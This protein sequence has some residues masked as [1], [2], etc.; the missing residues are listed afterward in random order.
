MGLTDRFCEEQQKG[1]SLGERSLLPNVKFILRKWRNKSFS[2]ERLHPK[3]LNR[4]NQHTFQKSRS[5]EW[6][7]CF[8]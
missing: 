6:L 7:H 8:D 5:L 4:A 1:I 3:T 2:K